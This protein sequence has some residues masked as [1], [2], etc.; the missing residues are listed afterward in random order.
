MNKDGIKIIN[1]SRNVGQKNINE[2]YPTSG[3]GGRPHGGGRH[4]QLGDRH[5][6]G[7]TAVLDKQVWKHV[8]FIQTP[9]S[10]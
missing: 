6:G 5:D 8:S 4:G 2:L 10:K 3:I 7:G 9:Q 1:R